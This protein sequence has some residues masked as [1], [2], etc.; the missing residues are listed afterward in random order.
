LT[1]L[2]VPNDYYGNG[3]GHERSVVD[4]NIGLRIS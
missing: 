2:M 4:G 3:S 1:V